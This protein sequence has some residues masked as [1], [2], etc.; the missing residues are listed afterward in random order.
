MDTDTILNTI[1]SSGVK[2]IS[3]KYF[4]FKRYLVIAL[5]ITVTIMGA[6]V[7]AKI[8]A[9]MLLASWEYWDYIFGSF[10]Y[11]FYFSVPLL[12]VSLL[13]V[14]TVL[15]PFIIEQTKQG[16]KYKK[17]IIVMLSIISSI[18][19]GIIILK[20]GSFNGMNNYF[21]RDAV[22]RESMLWT[23]SPSGRISGEVVTLGKDSLILEDAR[24]KVWAVDISNILPASRE[25]LN[26]NEN[27]RIIGKELDENT[28]VACQIMPFP[29][30]GH[31]SIMPAPGE[32]ARFEFKN[33]SNLADDLCSVVIGD[34]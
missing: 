30:I 23:D 31:E 3:K 10:G 9:S 34:L 33:K 22:R 4:I 15:M 8:V 32:F 29:E 6:F 27:I 21:I 7:F 20:I 2:P 11:F 25:V 1:K 19:L 14:F 12:W 17:L 18:V 26:N 28:F 24:S 5:G 13:I 16:Y